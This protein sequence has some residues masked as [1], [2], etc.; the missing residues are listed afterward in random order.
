MTFS[1]IVLVIVLIWVFI[2]TSSYALWTWKEKNRLGGIM[3][4][5]VALAALVLPLYSVFIREG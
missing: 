3:V 5:I 2:Y 4:F 1:R